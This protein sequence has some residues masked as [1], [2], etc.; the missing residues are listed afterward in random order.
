MG[1]LV[2]TALTDFSDLTGKSGTLSLH[3]ASGYHKTCAE[4]AS[5]FVNQFGR[6]ERDIKNQISTVRMH[7]VQYSFLVL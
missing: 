6:P 5:L 3:A 2:R 4:R 7:Q 1:R